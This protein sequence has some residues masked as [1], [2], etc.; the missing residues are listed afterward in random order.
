MGGFV[1]AK[2]FH[3]IWWIYSDQRE[4][5]AGLRLAHFRKATNSGAL[6]VIITSEIDRHRNGVRIWD[7]VKDREG[8]RK[9]MQV[10]IPTADEIRAALAH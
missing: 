3:E 8:W 10:P 9:V 5:W 2:E 1:T 6:L 7:D 4:E